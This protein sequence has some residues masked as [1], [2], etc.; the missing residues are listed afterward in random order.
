M[1]DYMFRR[2]LWPV[3]LCVLV[4]IFKIGLDV[5]ICRSK[6]PVCT[7]REKNKTTKNPITDLLNIAKRKKM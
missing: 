7:P 4:Y 3:S 6:L 5:P 1:N 2:A